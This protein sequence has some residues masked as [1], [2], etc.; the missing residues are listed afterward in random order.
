MNNAPEDG[1][2]SG[3]KAFDGIRNRYW[4]IDNMTNSR[5]TVM[6]DIY[7]N[8]YRKGLDQLYDNE[9]TGRTNIL[10][11][12]NLLNTFNTDNPAT[13][14]ES[15]FFQGKATELIKIFSKASP[16]DKTSASEL[17]QRMDITNSSRYKDELN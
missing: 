3:W 1:G 8:Y 11:T 4:L 17:L 16:Q 6:H 13:M 5:Y 7:Y 12:L 2:I 14:I 9:A 15:F 10:S